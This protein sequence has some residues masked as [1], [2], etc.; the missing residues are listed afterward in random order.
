ME[1]K[2]F[3]TLFIAVFV[4]MIGA[5]II[6]PLLPIYAKNLGATGIWLGI[7]FSG[8]ALARLIFMPIIGKISDRKGRK[9]FIVFGL[10]GSSVTSLLYL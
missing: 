3:N 1:K 7:I 8:F 4:S 2:I 9:K 10:L 6:V 5:G